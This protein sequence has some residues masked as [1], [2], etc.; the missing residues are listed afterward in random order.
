MN[1]SSYHS[2]PSSL[3]LLEHPEGKSKQSGPFP[4]HVQPLSLLSGEAP[5]AKPSFLAG[6]LWHY[7]IQKSKTGFLW[8]IGNMVLGSLN[9]IHYFKTINFFTTETMLNTGDTSVKMCLLLPVKTSNSSNGEQGT[10]Y[11]GTLFPS[12]L[13]T[14]PQ[15]GAPCCCSNTPGT[16]LCTGCSFW[17]K[18][19]SPSYLHDSLPHFLQVYAQM[20]CSQ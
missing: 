7:Q 9:E 5:Q 19:S 20:S 12:L 1:D 8:L 6:G 14:L 17:P 11:F 10:T 18:C 3:L 2:L 16:G 4:A 15:H 13:F